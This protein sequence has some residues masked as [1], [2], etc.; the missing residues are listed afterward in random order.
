MVLFAENLSP[1]S[2]LL[3]KTS[4]YQKDFKMKILNWNISWANDT[5]SKIEYLKKQISGETF[6]MILQ[7]VKPHAYDAIE[8]HLSDIA[9]IEYSLSYRIPGKY[10]TDSR[11]LGVAILTSKD[12][13]VKKVGVLDRALM[14]D[15]TL[16]VD[17]VYKNTPLRILGLH[18]ITGCQHGKAKEIQYFSFAEA[19][20]TYKPD[21]V[22]IDA[23]EPQI[24]HYDIRQMNFF[25]N[26]QKGLG[27]KSFFESMSQ[28]NLVDAFVKE[29]DKSSFMTGEP[30][31]T[32]HIIKRGNKRVRYDF[33]FIN[34]EKFS[35]YLC[36][37]KYDEA[38]RAG[39]DHAVIL[40]HLSDKEL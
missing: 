3:R 21:I 31:A 34:E 32:S 28:N 19:I 2:P 11:K 1:P 12:I 26:H 14:P 6:I 4:K 13:T 23:N 8:E 9:K 10:D 40:C 39:S 38:I 37:Y 25:D 29:F 24:D 22:G 30:L 33:L 20:D 15:R 18:S 27:C 35:D 7:E 5:V 36:E 17:T 16:M